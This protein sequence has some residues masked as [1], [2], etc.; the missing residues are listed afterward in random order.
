MRRYIPVHL[1]LLIVLIAGCATPPPP[2]G[3][4]EKVVVTTKRVPILGS[5]PLLG[6]L[7]RSSHVERL[8]VADTVVP[9]SDSRLATAPIEE[10]PKIGSPVLQRWALVVGISKYKDTNVPRLQYASAD[11]KAFQQWLVS[12]SGGAYDPNHIKLLCDEQATSAAIRDALFNWLKQPIEEDLVTI[13]YAGHGSPESPDNLKNLFLLP[14]DV[15]YSKIGSTGFP[16]WDIETSLKR[17][18]RAKRVVI[19]ADACHAAGVGQQFDIARRAGRGMKVNPIGNGL[20]SLSSIGE[21]VCVLSAAAASQYSQEG[22]RWGGGHGVFTY[23]LLQGLHGKADSNGDGTVTVGELTPYV[24][25][26]VRRATGS[27]QCPRMAGS[28]DPALTIGK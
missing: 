20:A 4:N 1:A 9:V 17:F 24:S 22:E 13:Y 15:D 8:P 10:T 26:Q 23:Y 27:A 16:M 11:A 2:P 3:P 14:H 7:F 28:Y 6:R 18:I 12:P 21:S 25:E 5:L 19:I